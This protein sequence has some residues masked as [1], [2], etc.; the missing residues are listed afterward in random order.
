MDS[1]VLHTS[2]PISP[3]RRIPTKGEQATLTIPFQFPLRVLLVTARPE[4]AGFIDPQ[5][6]SRELVDELERQSEAE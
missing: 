2:H 5:S 4:D 3:V 1:L 6:I